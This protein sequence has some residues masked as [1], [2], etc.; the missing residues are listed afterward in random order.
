VSK[1][2]DVMGDSASNCDSPLSELCTLVGHIPG[3]NRH[4]AL[5]FPERLDD[6]IADENPVRF[7]DACVNALALAT[8]GFQR[9]TAVATGRPA[10]PPGALLQLDLDG[11]LDRLR[12]SRRLEQATHRNVELVWLLKQLR[13]DHKTMAMFRRDHLQRLRQVW[14]A[15]TLLGKQLDL[16]SG[17]LVAIA[18][19]QCKAVNAQ[20]RHFTQSK[21]QR[22]LPQIDAPIEI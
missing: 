22:L 19:S 1:L 10:Y 6:Y 11:D 9:V 4:E 8:L 18:G 12:S 13:P 5:L 2:N 21:L 7:L 17:E 3:T 16:F 15:C 14:R 20:E